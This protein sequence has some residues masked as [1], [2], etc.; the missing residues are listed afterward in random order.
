MI[1]LS[2]V[3][4]W[5]IVKHARG[6]LLL[7]EHSSGMRAPHPLTCALMIWLM[8]LLAVLPAT[9]RVMVLHEAMVLAP[10]GIF[11]TSRSRN[12]GV[13]L[14]STWSVPV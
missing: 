7:V 10:A 5:A 3:A 11:P 1:Q 9:T 12:P 2:M 8:M 4:I 13:F 6:L 14:R